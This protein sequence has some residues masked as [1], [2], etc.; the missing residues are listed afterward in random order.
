MITSCKLYTL[1]L[2]TEYGRLAMEDTHKKPFQHLHFLIRDWSYP[3][4]F[5]YGATGGNQL[6]DKRLQVLYMPK[7][8]V[9]L[10]D[11]KSAY[12]YNSLFFVIDIALH[13]LV[14]RCCVQQIY[15][16]VNSYSAI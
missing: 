11:G 6:L 16:V 9:C 13:R 3:Y 12:W 15:L 8:I 5:E 2:F 14:A 1:Q 10:S 4:Q 7:F